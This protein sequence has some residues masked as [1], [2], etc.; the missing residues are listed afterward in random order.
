MGHVFVTNVPPCF[1][2]G[3]M[4][5]A[6]GSTIANNG[7]VLQLSSHTVRRQELACFSFWYHMFGGKGVQLVVKVKAADSGPYKHWR[8]RQ[9]LQREGRTT[10]DRWY[11]VRRTVYLYDVENKIE[12]QLKSTDNRQANAVM[13][14]GPI[15]FTPGAC[16]V[17]TDAKGYCDFEFD[18]CGW[19]NANGWD[20]KMRPYSSHQPDQH[21]RSGPVNS[22]F[23]LTTKQSSCVDSDC[24]VNSP[25]WTGQ[26]GPQ[27]LEFWYLPAASQDAILK[28]EVLVNGKTE[29]LWSMPVHSQRE[30]T[31]ARVQFFQENAFQVVFRARLPA[32]KVQSFSLDDVA[33]RPEPCSHLAECNFTD[34]LCGYVNK[35]ERDF[36][37]LVGAGR[38]ENPSLQPAIPIPADAASSFAY[39]DLTAGRKD[40]LPIPKSQLVKAVTLHSA[41]FDVND[42][43]KKIVVQYFRNGQDIVAAN[44]SVVCYGDGTSPKGITQYSQEVAEVT[45]WTALGVPLKRGTNCRLAVQVTRGERTNGAMAV[46]SIQ[47]V[48]VVPDVRPR[49]EKDSAMH[50]TFEDGTMC[51]W[52]SDGTALAW[53]LNDPAN[54]IPAFPRSDHTLRAYRGRFIFTDNKSAKTG[55]VILKSPQLNVKETSGL[56]LSFWH[57]SSNGAPVGLSVISGQ[58]SVLQVSVVTKIQTRHR[59]DH[60]L[61]DIKRLSEPFELQIRMT[62]EPGLL[63]LDDLQITAGTCPERDFCSWENDTL[64]KF[65]QSQGNV[66]PWRIRRADKVG[67]PDHTTG[68]LQGY[69]LYLNTTTLDSHH[70]VS[71][72][73]MGQRPPTKASCVTFRWRGQGVPSKL[74]VYRFTKETAL[75]DALIT[76]HTEQQGDWW[77]ARSVSV[78]SKKKWNLVFEVIAPAGN[79][80]PSGVMVDDVEFTE[81]ECP[82]YNF[83]TF[84][85]ECLPWRV[86]TEED[87][88]KFEVQR[89]GSFIKLPHDHT[90]LTEDGYYL[91]YKSP[92]LQGNRTS[93]QLRE[94]SLYRCVSLWYYLP[95]LSNGVQLHLEGRIATPENV[96]KKQ[97]FRPSFRGTVIP[98]EALS[99]SSAEGFVAIDDVLID[100]KDCKNELPA[101]E[102]QC[103]AKQAVPMEKVCDF[104]PD[105]DN[106]A[107]ERKCGA[108]DFSVDACGWNLDD[109]R[110]Q[111]ATAWRLERVGDVPQ[112]PMERT[113]GS[114]SGNYL[115]LYGNKTRS[116]EHGRASIS[117]PTIRNTNKLCTLEFWYNFAKNGASLDVEL[118][119]TVDGFTMAVWSLGELSRIPK[120]GV[121]TRASV[122]I[123]RYPREVSFSFSTNQYP[124]SK[125]MFAVDAI[126]YSGCALPAKQEEC[127]D[128]NFHCANGACVNSYDRCNY[129]DDCGDNSDELNC[130]DHRLGCNFDTSFCDWTPEAPSEGNWASWSLN[131]PSS[132]LSAGPTRDHTTGTHEGK[133][134]IFQSS[135]SKT[136]ATIVGPTLDN[137]QMCMITFFYTVQGRSEPLL[138]LNVRTT[139]DG[140]WKSVWEQQRT[141]EFFHF[142]AANVILKQ[143]EPYQVAFTAQHRIARKQGYVAIDDVTFSESCELHHGAL[144]P[145]PTVTPAPFTCGKGEFQCA[146]SMECIPLT[147]VCDFKSDCSDGADEARCGACEFASDLCGLENEYPHAR[148]GWNWTKVQDAKRNKFFPNTDSRLSEDGA[149]AMYSLLN[150][151]VPHGGIDKAMIT[152]RL[153][154][155]ARSCVVTFYAFVPDNPSSKLFFGVLPPSA[156]ST[157]STDIALLADVRGSNLKGRWAAVSVKTGNWAAGARFVYIADTPGIS[158][159]RPEYSNCHPDDQSEG[160]E[161]R[162]QVSCDFSNPKDCGW[163]PERRDA[164]VDW[165]LHIGANDTGNSSFRWQPPD[166]ASGNGAYMYSQNTLLTRRTAHLVSIRIGPTPDDGRCFTFWYNMWHPNRGD[167]NLLQRVGNAST[168]LLWSRTAPQGKEWQQGQV[169]L[170]SDEP[171]QLMFEAVLNPF[172]SGIIAIDNF[173]LKDGPCGS[174]K[175]CTF[176]K[177]ACGWELH[178]WVTAESSSVSLPQGDHTTR[179]P[180][181]RFAL[182]QLPSGRMVSPRGW[183]DPS[184]N[185]CL[186]FWF[187]MA[188]TAAER[189]N[190]TRVLEDSQEEESI[191]FET[192]ANL[193]LNDW[194]SAAVNLIGHKGNAVTVFEASTSGEP[195]TAVAVDD[196]TLGDA[197]CPPPGSCSFEEDMC[198]WHN[199]RG[200]SYAQWYR[201]KGRT[202]S[203][204]SNLEKD[205][206]LGTSEGYYLLLDSEDLSSM[207]SGSLQS[208][209]LHLGPL[210]CF[211]FYYHMRKASATLNITF[212]D[213][214]GVPTGETT[215]ASGPKFSEWTLL[216]IERTDLPPVFSILI[217]A[218]ATKFTG[219]IAIDDIDV[220]PAKCTSDTPATTTVP[221]ST[222]SSRM[223]PTTA[224]PVEPTAAEWT[225]EYD[226]EWPTFPTEDVIPLTP[227]TAPPTA[228][229]PKPKPSGKCSR[230]QFDCRDGATCIPALLLCD[231]VPDCPNGLDEKCG[232]DAHCEEDEFYC[233]SRDPFVCA[234][235]AFLC[236]DHEDCFGGAD[237][238]MCG[239]CPDFLCLNGGL[240]TWTEYERSPVCNC[241]EGY[242]GSRCQ[243]ISA[244]A[245]DQE[246]VRGNVLPFIAVLRK[247]KYLLKDHTGHYRKAVIPY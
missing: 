57:F 234:P 242:K 178:N 207:A 26:R 170:R 226:S 71:R 94:P 196:I 192:A 110:N 156:H 92:G 195:G 145:T 210:V 247:L 173:T 56:C 237:E 200:P 140:Q 184:Q 39:L 4:I 66:S 25:L 83:C 166:S 101:Q 205:H 65:Y 91:L 203:L 97:Q 122:D 217:T 229:P 214:S 219:S 3:G 8:S 48:S 139:K 116:T 29:N 111:G 246:Y 77:N 114:S 223:P 102:F 88:A 80:R 137:K 189:L 90:T 177:D 168:T 221:H 202:A 98:V 199:N 43:Q 2:A 103:T 52:N 147:K 63:A 112:S 15:D 152:P 79:K 228:A 64:C 230:G 69:Y 104:V 31:L 215:I 99:G 165:V 143:S 224:F 129:V 106:S 144:P 138:S 86:S 123:G 183:Y 244:P 136:N 82:P 174:G 36:R 193:R 232:T 27:C 243:L 10:T 50:C 227:T 235:R 100:E 225:T 70:P 149:Y 84:E 35:F 23:V 13:A 11:N 18:Q 6:N 241:S 117:S 19:A 21:V 164:D 127:P 238:F 159:D 58:G 185:K 108:C 180:S 85:D 59:W 28:A 30:W 124:Q 155:I 188:G 154:P 46:N 45:E 211:Q 7:G 118:Y 61:F 44:L 115:L 233:A 53:T 142:T 42:E 74:S 67:V 119:M 17:L 208:Q 216:S 20:R 187:F 239:V 169:Q 62:L 1:C 34:G 14:L 51:G 182:A 212:L 176:E 197:A 206:T 218:P 96:W 134:L 68:T 157:I 89:S 32:Q 194:Y 158:V 167:L 120:E 73:F 161:A 41:P 213:P 172:T 16:D 163:F 231:G 162:L 146:D 72:A 222:M 105:C 33:L 128:S 47:L 78:S 49:A 186:R 160:W 5:H 121:W 12:F 191:W 126:L 22:A 209:T 125:A 113:T 87:E 240:C 76:L 150:P 37:W 54:G 179:A 135:L 95:T 175:G 198:N 55:N 40:N 181:G 24:T 204:Y 107:D 109:A 130:G 38:L 220:R 245:S 132:Y 81:G 153:G 9:L 60:A 141:T 171:H 131:S 133:F 190:V 75:R 93:L 148:F 236:D 151:E 201:Q